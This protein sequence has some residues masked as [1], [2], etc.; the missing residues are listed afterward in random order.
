MKKGLMRGLTGFFASLLAIS[1]VATSY[2]AIRAAFI[3][4]RLG[5]SS[6]KLVETGDTTVDKYYYKSLRK[7]S[8][9]VQTKKQHCAFR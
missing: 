3:N 6:T 7:E 2:T 1:L 5:T 9:M 8:K 4:T